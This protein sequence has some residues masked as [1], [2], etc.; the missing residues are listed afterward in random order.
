MKK[1]LTLLLLSSNLYFFAQAPEKMTYQA[2]IR[3]ASNILV[4]NSAIGTKVSILQGSASGSSVFI[5]THNASTNAN[6]LLTLEIGTGAILSGNFAAIDWANGPFFI[7][8]ES[9][10]NGGTNYTITGTSQLLSV[11]YALYAKNSGSSIPGP[12]GATGPQGPAGATGATGPAGPQGP[13]GATGATGATGPQGPAGPDGQ[14]LSISGNTLSISGGNSVTL[15]TSGGSG[16]TLDQAYDFGG[17][18]LGRSITT[19]A[20][21]VQINNGGT[22]TTALEINSAVTNS[23]GVL[24][25]HSG[26]GVA[27]RAESTN[28]SNSF[29]AIQS[30]SN[31]SNANVS[32]IL[33][34]NTGAGY[35]VSGQIPATAT[36]FA[37]VYGSNLRTAGGCGVNGIGF[38]G[39][40]GQTNFGAGYGLY[41]N[42]TAASGLRI[43]TYGIGFNGVYGQ[44]TDP[45]NGWAGYYT[46]D[47]GCD[48]AGYALGGWIN[49]SDKRLKS[50]IIPIG[51]ALEKISLINGRH[52]TI[53]TKS[54]TPEGEIISTSKEQYG[55]IA[56]EVEAIFPE[57]VQEKALFI[58]TGDETLYKA[59]DYNQ[60]VP[61]LIEAIKELNIQ[62]ETLKGVI[63]ELKKD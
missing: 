41:G 13:A 14:T 60:L 55:V 56:Q 15:P 28:P 59:V 39:V 29:S 32:A 6:G 48:G 25:T 44:T 53:T 9:D 30:N 43:G 16:G 4:S 36:G 3:D 38:N 11:P 24:S 33:G 18:G 61:V 22:N 5:E 20:G 23:S 2:V 46:A 50:N 27:L 42:N 8:T 40:V 12:Q 37:A 19:D 51:N 7:K 57:M 58:N 10:L 31:S 34:N 45:V 54:K 35:G 26:L 21:S 17:S 52:Y 47:I 49:A 1:L 63:E 62:V